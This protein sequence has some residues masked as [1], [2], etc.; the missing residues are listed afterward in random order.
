ML[1]RSRKTRYAHVVLLHSADESASLIGFERILLPSLC[2]RLKEIENAYLQ[3]SSF[4]CLLCAGDQP[5]NCL[6]FCGLE[7]VYVRTGLWGISSKL[8][9]YWPRKL[10][11]V[12]RTRE[13]CGFLCEGERRGGNSNTVVH[14]CWSLVHWFYIGYRSIQICARMQTYVVEIKSVLAFCCRCDTNSIKTLISCDRA[15]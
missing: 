1:N 6:G 9:A 15:S 2:C 11:Y 8:M 10:Y 12:N 3:S 7:Y 14:A 13:Q 5:R 4:V